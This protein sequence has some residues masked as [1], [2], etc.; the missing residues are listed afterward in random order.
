[1]KKLI[2]ASTSPYKQQLLSKIVADFQTVNP[3]YEET[4]KIDETPSCC[5]QRLAKGKAHAAF[6]Q[7]NGPDTDSAVVIGADQVCVLPKQLGNST[8][9]ILH[10][11]GNLAKA[12]EALMLCSGKLVEYHTA[13]C[14]I[15]GPD[16]AEFA[17][18]DP[19]VLVFRAFN[20]QE[21]ADYCALDEPFDCAGAI[22][23]E[24]F[25]VNL[26]AEY[27]GNDPHTLVGLPLIQLRAVLAQLN[28]PVR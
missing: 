7:L 5:A 21:A 25:G 23:T 24:S 15:N 6:A 11:P 19:Y 14:V 3:H 8:E 22:K 4:H 10:K 12:I 13:A 16:Q 17:I 1:M 28:I 26:I 20:E 27:R 2:L 9:I 18:Q